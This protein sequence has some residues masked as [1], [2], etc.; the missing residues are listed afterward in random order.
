MQP[1]LE[2]RSHAGSRATCHSSV[3]TETHTNRGGNCPGEFVTE[4]MWTELSTRFRNQKS[5]NG[6]RRWCLWD[7]SRPP[8]VVLEYP[9]LLLEIHDRAVTW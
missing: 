3:S 5:M 7:T 9:P 6:N 1:L 2:C 8:Q 4:E